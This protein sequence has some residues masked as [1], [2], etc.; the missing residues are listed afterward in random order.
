M[1]KSSALWLDLLQDLKS[2]QRSVDWASQQAAQPPPNDDAARFARDFTIGGMVHNCFGAMERALERIVTDIDGSLPT[3]GDRHRDL[4]RRAAADIPGL[5]PPIISRET[6]ADLDALRRFRH[7]F[8]HVYDDYDYE[9]A[10][11]NVS[12]AVRALA[13]FRSDLRSFAA[14]LDVAFDLE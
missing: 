9:K 12:T 11:E 10:L 7:A 2:A 8:R 14:K 6:A 1:A 3:G 5:R 13:L 4:L